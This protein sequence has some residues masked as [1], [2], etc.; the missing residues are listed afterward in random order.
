M[1]I[2]KKLFVSVIVPAYNSEKTIST[3]LK[4][5]KKQNYKG[6]FE[7]I[8]VDDGSNDKTAEIS[9]NKGAV[10]LRQKNAGPAKARNL[11]AKKAK[12]EILLFT[13]ADCE[14]EKN[15]VEEMLRPF[16]DNGIIGVQG[17]Y[18]T[19][20][21]GVV[22][23][24][25]QLEIEQRYEKMEK[26]R[27]ID[28]VGSYSA[29]YRK[30]DFDEAGGFDESFPKASGEDPELSYKISKMGKK[31]FFNH[32]AIVYHTHPDSLWQYLKVKYFRAYY[33]I[34]LYSKHTDK[35]AGDSYTPGAIKFQLFAAFTGLFLVLATFPLAY[36]GYFELAILSGGASTLIAVLGLLSTLEF[37]FY[38]LPKDLGVAAASIVIIPLRTI[39]FQLGIIFG[40]LKFKI[41]K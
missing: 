6:T 28:W 5:L 24:F 18:K 20:Q 35:I 30:K 16:A 21:V 15:W 17:A 37:T 38:V 23:R 33:R 7:V 32:D 29:A 4:S 39:A 26:S 3:L 40:T 36:A 34:L 25:N 8:V 22:A 12:G 27:N 41:L 11:G 10:V 19:K 13:D 31:L 1:T 9:E 14:P 2:E